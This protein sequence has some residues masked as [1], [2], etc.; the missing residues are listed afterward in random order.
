MSFCREWYLRNAGDWS[1]LVREGF[2]GRGHF[3]AS[4]FNSEIT[5]ED[6]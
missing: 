4:M 5:K 6:L 3:D 2:M 1:S